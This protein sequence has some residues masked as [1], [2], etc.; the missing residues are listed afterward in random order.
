MRHVRGQATAR[1]IVWSL[2]VAT[3]AWARTCIAPQVQ[4]HGVEAATASGFEVLLVEEIEARSSLDLVHP[5]APGARTPNCADAECAARWARSSGADAALICRL[6]RLGTKYVVTLQLVDASSG[7]TAW[8]GRTAVQSREELDA[9]AVRLARDLVAAGAA[10]A[11]ASPG[12][13][14]P[15]SLPERRARTGHGPRVGT[16]YPVSGSYA[17]VPRLTGLAYAW[18]YQTTSFDVETVPLSGLAWGGDLER[19]RGRARDWSMLDVYVTWTPS[20]RDV[21]PHLGAGMGLHAVRLERDGTGVPFSGRRDESATTLGLQLGGG[22][23]LFRTYDFRIGVDLRY[24]CLLHAFSEV[25]GGGAQGL[26]LTLSLQ[27]R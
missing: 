21:A 15:D 23:S 18:H 8:S 25:G 5:P 27:H 20:R 16:V 7:K 3:P 26:A 12:R 6:T 9:A 22:L 4:A 2:L 10:P 19:D 11:A 1:A 13:E 14:A 24:L 17:G